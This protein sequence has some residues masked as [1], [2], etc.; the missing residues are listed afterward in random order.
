MNEAT[1][2]S[3]ARKFQQKEYT[4]VHALKGGWIEWLG[5]KYPTEPKK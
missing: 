1:S 2:A 5:A 3:V 4:K